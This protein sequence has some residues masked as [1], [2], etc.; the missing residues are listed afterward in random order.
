MLKRIF[1]VTFGSVTLVVAAPVMG[2]IALIIWLESPGPVIFVQERIGVN[3]RSFRL[4]KFRKFPVN[5]GDAGPGVTVNGDIRMTGLGRFLE[6]TKLDELPQLWNILKGEMSFVGP[7]PE[8]KRFAHLFSG[9]YKAVLRY[10]PGIFGPSQVQYRN[11][12]MLYP[13]DEDPETYYCRVIFPAKT[14]IDTDYYSKAYFHSDIGWLIRGITVSIFGAI[15]WKRIAARGGQIIV[16]AALIAVAWTIANYVR[17]L[18]IPKGEDFDAFVSGLMILP[19][20]L[21]LCMN[22]GGCYRY[23]LWHFAAYDARRMFRVVSVGWL[24]GY[25][26]VLWSSTR[27]ASFSLL[28][29]GWLHS[30]FLL[31]IPRMWLRMRKERGHERPTLARK[32]LV[33]GAGRAGIALAEWMSYGSD[34]LRFIGFIDDNPNLRGNTVSGHR[35]LGWESD[36]PTV[37]KV[38][39]FTE[40]WVTYRPD[41]K[42]QSRLEQWCT[43][44]GIRLFILC[45]LDPFAE[46]CENEVPHEGYG[47]AEVWRGDSERR[48]RNRRRVGAYRALGAPIAV[49]KGGTWPVHGRYEDK[50]GV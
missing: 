41:E 38:Y 13:P 1:D 47:Q 50:R 29:L 43:T 25:L 48:F 3:G 22:I 44:N 14:K 9:E 16:D 5:W 30:L 34:S 20:F 6:R 35:V 40:I 32:V 21:I 11:E 19:L 2:I 8:S 27:T 18:D 28:L 46:C 31:A 24:A 37:Q 15:N 36:I 45:G 7:R 17:F 10:V 26:L 42:K 49:D 12:G 33:Y 4:Y 23:P 39:G